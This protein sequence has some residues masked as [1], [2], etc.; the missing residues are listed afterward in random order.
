MNLYGES[1]QIS[2]RKDQLERDG[3]SLLLVRFDE[4]PPGKSERVYP[5]LHPQSLR[6]V[7]VGM[8]DLPS[9]DAHSQKQLDQTPPHHTAELFVVTRRQHGQ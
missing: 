9:K 3:K 6:L 4:L 7:P 8:R 1:Y 2:G 5:T